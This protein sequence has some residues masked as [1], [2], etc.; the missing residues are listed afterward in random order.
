MTISQERIERAARALCCGSGPCRDHEG[1]AITRCIWRTYA[2][3]ARAAL[4]ADA[5]ALTAARVAE[6]EGIA[7]I[8]DA[9]AQHYAILMANEPSDSAFGAAATAKCGALASISARISD[10]I[11]AL[12][13]GKGE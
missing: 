4:E 1:G 3:E 12:E 10:R 5:D 8:I 7:K 2:D 11:R 9:R 6:L 13:E